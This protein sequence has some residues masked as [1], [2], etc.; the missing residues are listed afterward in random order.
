LSQALPNQQWLPTVL[1]S[2]D[3]T[4]I[5]TF[6]TAAQD[7]IPMA[8]DSINPLENNIFAA[9]IEANDSLLFDQLIAAGIDPNRFCTPQQN[10]LNLA[11]THNLT[12]VRSKLLAHLD[13][14]SVDTVD[15]SGTSPLMLA[16]EQG[17]LSVVSN[18][19]SLHGSADTANIQGETALHRVCRVSREH[20]TEDHH[21]IAQQL[22]NAMSIPDMTDSQGN[23][24]AMVAA[25]A[26]N[27]RLCN[28][29]LAHCDIFT[30]NKA[31]QHLLFLPST[32][33]ALNLAK[34]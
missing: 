5:C 28:L 13:T 22:L 19:L 9:A 10:L 18:I 8:V 15:A 29:C 32:T 6:L 12:M 24:P 1:S 34:P 31:G 16:A 2:L 27:D 33:V 14:E 25:L 11:L 30:C 23:N 3:T 17:N 4:A 7:A 21:L 26:G 20:I